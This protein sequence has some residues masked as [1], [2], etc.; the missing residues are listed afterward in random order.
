MVALIPEQSAL[1][2]ANEGLASSPRP[3]LAVQSGLPLASSAAWMNVSRAI[4]LCTPITVWS[5]GS[6]DA[7]IVE[8]TIALSKV[9]GLAVTAEGIE[10]HATFEWLKAMG[11][12]EGQGYYFGKPMPAAQFE[13]TFLATALSAMPT[14]A[15]LT[16]PATAA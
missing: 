12:E 6:S 13:E 16:N 9:L 2:Q 10:Q 8:S 15:G 4:V 5:P 11:C 7:A 1:A 14:I 3:A